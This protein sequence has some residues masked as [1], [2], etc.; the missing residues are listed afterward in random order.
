MNRTKFARLHTLICGVLPL[1]AIAALPAA[2]PGKEPRPKCAA[3]CAAPCV[4]EE[5]AIPVLSDIPYLGRLF[6]TVRY[7]AAPQGN[8]PLAVDFDFEI[9]PDCPQPGVARLPVPG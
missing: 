2:L 5:I 1:L 9:C 8:E 6:K 7:V 4:A 3:T